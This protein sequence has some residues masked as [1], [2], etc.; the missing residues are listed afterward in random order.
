MTESKKIIKTFPAKHADFYAIFDDW[1]REMNDGGVRFN[2]P[3]IQEKYPI[4]N[5]QIEITL[6]ETPED[7]EKELLNAYL[8]EFGELPPFNRSL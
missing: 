7:L 6:S 1:R 2:E 8:L 5:S 3:A 4:K